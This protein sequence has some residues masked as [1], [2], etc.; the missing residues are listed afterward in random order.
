[1]KLTTALILIALT[2]HIDALNIHQPHQNFNSRPRY[3]DVIIDTALSSTAAVD[4][5]HNANIQSWEDQREDL[6]YITN[7]LLQHPPKE[8]NGY[9]N[10]NNNDINQMHN[11]N[12]YDEM[13]DRINHDVHINHQQQFRD[14]SHPLRNYNSIRQHE[15]SRN[16]I[17]PMHPNHN[18]RVMTGAERRSTWGSYAMAGTPPRSIQSNNVGGVIG[19]PHGRGDWEY[20]SMYEP[21]T[22]VTLNEVHDDA[23]FNGDGTNDDA[24]T[25]GQRSYNLGNTVGFGSPDH[26]AAYNGARANINSR[27]ADQRT[28]NM[29][30]TVGFGSPSHHTYHAAYSAAMD[31]TVM[32]GAKRRATY[33]SIHTYDPST[34]STNY[35][36]LTE[37]DHQDSSFNTYTQQ[38]V[39][40]GSDDLRSIESSDIRQERYISG[41]DFISSFTQQQQNASEELVDKHEDTN[42]F[43][44]SV[45]TLDVE[46]ASQQ[47]DDSTEA[48]ATSNFIPSATPLNDAATPPF[49]GSEGT[50][51]AMNG[52]LGSGMKGSSNFGLKGQEKQR[53]S[54]PFAN[55]MKVESAVGP[56]AKSSTRSFKAPSAPKFNGFKSPSV[57]MNGVGGIG[58]GMQKGPVGVGLKGKE[59]GKSV[60]G[61]GMKSGPDLFSK[62]SAP[63]TFKG[64]KQTSFPVN[65]MK[66]RG[67]GM[68]QGP[69]DIG[70][71]TKQQKGPLNGGGL[72]GSKG[73]APVNGGFGSGLKPPGSFGLGLKGKEQKMKSG[74]GPLAKSTSPPF[75]T[76]SESS[77]LPMNGFK[78]TTVGLKVKGNEA[79]KE[80]FGAVKG[81]GSAN[82]AGGPLNNLFGK[83]STHVAF[84]GAGG[85]SGDTQ[86]EGNGGWPKGDSIFNPVGF[87]SAGNIGGSNPP[88]KIFKPFVPP[89]QAQPQAQDDEVS[90]QD[91]ASFLQSPNNV[92]RKAEDVA[93]SL[94]ALSSPP[95]FY[96]DFESSETHEEPRYEDES[97]ESRYLNFAVSDGVVQELPSVDDV[98]MHTPA[99]RSLPPYLSLHP[100]PGKGL[101]VVTNK[102]FKIGE[103]VGNYEGE[104]MEEEVKGMSHF[105]H[106]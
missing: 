41:A 66:S 38:D 2:I 18:V 106:D 87:S 81:F 52:G 24:M 11:N 21:P 46:E 92:K 96:N 14:N 35:H 86:T 29:G 91:L 30:N 5:Q 85:P 67:L 80:V 8:K 61:S 1:M 19:S 6:D 36:Y 64:T 70:L 31:R 69:G 49:K 10:N 34:T 53:K 74:A 57:S 75:K 43:E 55:G 22:S 26:H 40:D 58:G 71:K 59:Q 3:N 105:S 50:S 101:G 102:P 60:F 89:V 95:I 51:F 25:L 97:E 4:Y 12:E 98:P 27:R 68:P 94:S 77:S 99:R 47:Q 84:K 45:P 103:F 104:I 79:S 62:S 48:E 76:D 88:K 72:F 100:I 54:S 56:F 73:N 63:T 93:A 28:Y 65:G 20:T 82:G 42:G 13:K 7:A 83:K 9:S 90:N 15:H 16:N 44:A 32:T 23:G 17:S 78:K 33:Q 37:D 39:M